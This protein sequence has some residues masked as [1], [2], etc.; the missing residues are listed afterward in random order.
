MTDKDSL[1]VNLESSLD[2]LSA[3]EDLNQPIIPE[4]D[5]DATYF[6]RS[7]SESESCNNEEVNQTVN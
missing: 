5:S 1:D 4:P 3:E 2:P 6:S 7:S